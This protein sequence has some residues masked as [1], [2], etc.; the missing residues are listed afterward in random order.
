MIRI[1]FIVIDKCPNN[2]INEMIEE[3][4]KRLKHYCVFELLTISV[5]KT[6]RQKSIQEQKDEE[7]KLIK[8][9]LKDNDCLILLD[10]TGKEFTSVNFSKWIEKQGLSHSKLSF[11]IGGPYGVSDNVKAMANS[12]MALSQMT[13]SHE[14][15]RVIFLEQLYRA[16]TIIN[17]QKYHH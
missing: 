16:F 6:V 8:R 1:Q 3:Y 5:P 15:V 14:M 10:E 17:N 11:L 9:Y 12:T 2:S 7:E 13:F 4:S